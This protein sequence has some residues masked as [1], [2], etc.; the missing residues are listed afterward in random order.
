VKPFNL[1]TNDFTVSMSRNAGMNSLPLS[2][3]TVTHN[4]DQYIGRCLNALVP[5]VEQ[6]GGEVIVVDN[7]SDD[8][9]A[10]I[11]LTFITTPY[12]LLFNLSPFISIV[13]YD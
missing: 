9:S 7:A 6:L 12:D 3:I 10:A 8:E 1:F 11:A 4:H 13:E 5:E 2:T